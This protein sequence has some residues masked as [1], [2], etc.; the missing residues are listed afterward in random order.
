[1]SVL[2]LLIFNKWSIITYSN[3]FQLD[4]FDIGILVVIHQQ[5]CKLW[6]VVACKRTKDVMF[7]KLSFNDRLQV[8]KL[9]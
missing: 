9:S 3:G 4:W 2:A 6:D 8:H 7:T 5:G 1:M